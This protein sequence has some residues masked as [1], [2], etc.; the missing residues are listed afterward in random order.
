MLVLE[1]GP[2]IAAALT[3]RI[4]GLHISSELPLPELD[5]VLSDGSPDVT[6][7]RGSVPVAMACGEPQGLSVRPDGAVLNIIGVA[8]YWIRAGCEIIVE[9]CPGASDRN[10]RLFLLGSAFAAVLHQ[11]GLLPLH[12]NA[13]EFEGRAVAFMGHSGAGKS[14]LAAW[15]HDRGFNILADDVCVV[16]TEAGKT[17][18]HTGIPRLRLWKDAL[19]LTGRSV[20]DYEASFDDA[21]KYNLPTASR[22]SSDRIE[23]SHVYLLVKAADAAPAISRL[24][25]VEAVEALIE[26]TYRGRYLPMMGA[27]QQHLLQCLELVNNVP[28]FRAKRVWGTEGFDDQATLLEEHA[29]AVLAGVNR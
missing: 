27:S 5:S 24:K 10:L 4:F 1:E 19:E 6:I 15:F 2:P 20:S 18:A 14:T 26:N 3:Y 16:R 13:I 25:G 28:V 21:E 7:R 11:R 9:P 23:L 8:R 22:P 17:F 12:A 29:R